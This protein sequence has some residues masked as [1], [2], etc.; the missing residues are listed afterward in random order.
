MK[1]LFYSVIA[2]LFL[3]FSAGA[4]TNNPAALG[5]VLTRLDKA[6]AAGD[7]EQLAGDFSRI[8]ASSPR[9][10]LP[11]Y[12][13]AYCY[14]KAAWLYQDDPDKIEPL[15]NQAETLVTKAGT[16]ADTAKNKKALSEIYCV[17]SILNR[18]RVFINPATYGPQYGPAASRYTRLALQANPLNP[19]A[20]YLAG[21]EKYATPKMWGGDKKQAKE[22]LT[23][24]QQLAQQ[25]GGEQDPHWGKKEIDALLQQL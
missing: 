3:Q 4:Q 23:K 10:W 13:A 7:Y 1:K 5:P 25:P 12:Y 22:L 9:E 18:A 14:A 24:A 17:Q 19:R 21:W 15:A 11:Y 2:V 8:A 20:Y 6:A 16:L